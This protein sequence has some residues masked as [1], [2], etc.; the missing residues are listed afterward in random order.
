MRHVSTEV[1]VIGGGSTGTGTARDLA[2]RGFQT[3]LVEKRDLTHG[4]TGRYHG[5]LHSGGRYVVKD[6][7]SAKE[8][9][10]ENYI[11]R[12]I[13]PHC[14]EDTSGF[15]VTTPWDDP[16]FGDTFKAACDKTGVPCTE[17]PVSEALRR[18][19][20]L[21]S[22]TLRV[23]EVPDGSADSF[24]ATRLT[25]RSAEQ[26]GASI[27]PYHEVIGLIKDG[28]KIVGV[29]VKDTTRD[30]EY[31]IDCDV[32]VNASG[33]WAGQIAAM[34]GCVANVIPGKGVMVATNHRLVNTVLNRCKM[35]ADGD[36]IV[37]IHTVSVIGTTD[38]KVPDPEHY[39]I[40]PWEVE[41]MLE[42]GDKLVPGFKTSRIVRA[43]AGVRPLYQESA[44]ADTRDVTRTYTLLDHE[45]RDGIKGF[46]TITGGKWTT[47][48]QMAEVTVNAVCKKL[49]VE[50]PCRTAF[51]VLPGNED[52]KFY[53]LGHRL[54]EIEDANTYGDL[55]C[56]CEIVT[57]ATAKAAMENAVTL[58]DV[59][60]E[61][62]LGMGPCQGA[63]CRYRA[64]A[65]YQEVRGASVEETNLAL[66][67]FLQER[68]K[69]L[70][71]ILWGDQMR[72]AALDEI[73]YRGVFNVDNLETNGQKSP[74]TDFYAFE[75]Q[76]DEPVVKHT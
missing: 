24:M 33:A 43:W 29:Q 76:H 44:A 58:D 55:I 45:P 21:N 75:P 46:V 71:T 1:V 6:P 67:D 4:T 73:M 38:H 26:Y 63:F 28:D 5:L 10:E 51:E 66:L 3:I 32:V 72:E 27:R 62:R 37:P 61:T 41:L 60:R 25:A 53:T 48:R 40:E 20:R 47:F 19:P 8:C 11:L 35:P 57:S 22:K 68:W 50:R 70:T 54:K 2:M 65:L 17:I 16:A 18:E 59:R 39:G 14:L 12:R 13:M 42:E 36:I 30:E 74:M 49:G 52:G 23:F 64:A 9:I 31:I 15:F 69:G 34:A 7:V 56:E